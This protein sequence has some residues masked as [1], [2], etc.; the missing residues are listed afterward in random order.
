M[1]YHISVTRVATQK[2]L[3]EQQRCLLCPE[4]F[5]RT[6]ATMLDFSLL[7]SPSFVLLSLNAIFTSFGY[8]TPYMFVTDRAV[9]KDIPE[10]YAFWLISAIGVMSTFGRIVCGILGTFPKIR[11]EWIS[12]FCLAVG[13]VATIVSGISYDIPFQFFCAAMFGLSVGMSTLTSFYLYV[14][15]SARLKRFTISLEKVM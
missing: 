10:E 13:G 2:D 14:Y 3:E 5:K 9:Q 7:K 1:D 4:S 11:A 6:L 15:G 8:Y 12:F